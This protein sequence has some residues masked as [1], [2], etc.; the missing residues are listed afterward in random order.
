MLQSYAPCMQKADLASHRLF[1][2]SAWYLLKSKTTG[3]STAIFLRLTVNL[4]KT[5]IKIKILSSNRTALHALFSKSLC[6]KTWI[7]SSSRLRGSFILVKRQKIVQWSNPKKSRIKLKKDQ[8]QQLGVAQEKRSCSDKRR[9]AQIKHLDNHSLNTNEYKQACKR[10]FS[11]SSFNSS[12]TL[13][14]SLN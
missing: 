14:C 6:F 7:Y 2:Q 10:A 4:V 1:Q 12:L 9:I 11:L 5:T 3:L 13:P 8:N